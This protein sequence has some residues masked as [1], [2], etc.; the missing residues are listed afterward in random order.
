MFDVCTLCKLLWSPRHWQSHPQNCLP[1]VHLALHHSVDVT[2]FESWK[3]DTITTLL[4]WER[5]EKH[6]GKMEE[7]GCEHRGCSLMKRMDCHWLA[8]PH[9]CF[10]SN[11]HLLS[12]NMLMRRVMSGKLGCKSMHKHCTPIKQKTFFETLRALDIIVLYNRHSVFSRLSILRHILY[13]LCSIKWDIENMWNN[14]VSFPRL[15]PG[16]HSWK[17][18]FRHYNFYIFFY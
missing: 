3:C 18:V 7:L 17:H 6:V 11:F 15:L 4:G 12:E 14:S 8:V 9:V 2:T 16:S 5:R 1:W 13:L 10:Q